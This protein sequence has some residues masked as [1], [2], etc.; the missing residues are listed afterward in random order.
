[1]RPKD[2]E[3]FLTEIRQLTGLRGVAALMVVLGH[4]PALHPLANRV[5]WQTEA[6]DLFFCLSGVTLGIVYGFGGSKSLPLR[7]FLVA[8]IARV[9]PLYLVTLAVAAIGILVGF[10]LPGS[11]TTAGTTIGIAGRNFMTQALGV[12][13]WPWIGSCRP[14]G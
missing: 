6:V 10:N 1:M 9:Y 12:N 11:N 3:F 5:S 13:T 7:G 8:R 4:F 14:F 2:K